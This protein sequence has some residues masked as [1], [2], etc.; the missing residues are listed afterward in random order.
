MFTMSW[1]LPHVLSNNPRPAGAP[2]FQTLLGRGCLFE[3]PPPH[4]TRLLRH[5]ATRGIGGVRKSVKN[6]DE[7]TSVVLGQVKGQVTR[8][9]QRSDFAYFDNFRQTG[10]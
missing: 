10:A 1:L 3:H 9:H 6:N 4:L 5:V 7:M 2:G 8:G